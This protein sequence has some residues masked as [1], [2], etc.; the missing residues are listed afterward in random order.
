MY[1]IKNLLRFI[2][3]SAILAG[4]SG[5]NNRW[6]SEYDKASVST[7]SQLQYGSFSSGMYGTETTDSVAVLLPTSGPNAAIGKSIR[8][9]IEAA[10]MQFAGAG[11]RIDF[12]RPL[13]RILGSLLDQYLPKTRVYY[14]K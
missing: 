14:A 10:A 11:T 6:Y 13:H 3:A 12:G 4:C 9:A 2:C 5:T 7:P 1:I 8:P